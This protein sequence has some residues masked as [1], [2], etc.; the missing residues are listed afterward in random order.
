MDTFMMRTVIA[1]LLLAGAFC[2]AASESFAAPVTE[3]EA[4]AVADMWFANELNA[5]FTKIDAGQKAAQLKAMAQRQVLFL[6]SATDLLEQPPAKGIVLA[7][8]VKYKPAGYVVVSA[9]DRIQPIIA[10]D[11]RSEFRW[12]EPAINFMPE[13]LGTTMTARWANMNRKA[14]EAG[15]DAAHPNWDL[16]RAKLQGQAQGPAPTGSKA[17]AELTPAGTTYVL[18]DTAVWGQGNHYNE[19]CVSHNGGTDV[20]TGCTATA[21]AI[22]MRFFEWPVTGYSSHSYTDSWETVQYSHSV[23][24]GSHTYNWSAMPT[25]TLTVDNAHVANLMYDCGVAVEMN[26]EPDGSGAWPSP[27]AM[28]TYFR[29]RGTVEKTSGHE[30]PMRECIL[31]GVPVIISSNAHTVVACGYRDTVAPYFYFNAGWNGG[32]SGWYNYDDIPGGDLIERS[33]PYS[34]PNNYVYVDAAWGGSENGS[35]SNPYDTASEGNSAVPSG[36]HLMIKGG[37]YTGASNCPIVFSKAMEIKGYR[38]TV[39]IRK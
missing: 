18:W 14:A 12:D 8:V 37:T 19:T 20:P 16:L 10:F 2:L 7:Y 30:T 5:P 34:T 4:A 11:V 36:G 13:Y 24:F 22:L 39:V 33:Y 32:S 28:N 29:Y 17:T 31:S 3:A 26:Y 6:V 38:G 27:S 9:E 23:N 35:V 1:A 21:M 15:G 25:A